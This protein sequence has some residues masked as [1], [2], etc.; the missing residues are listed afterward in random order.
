LR[1]S[2]GS[3]PAPGES[4][5]EMAIVEHEEGIEMAVVEKEG[6]IESG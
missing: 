4:V 2:S 3:P 5:V 6:G 1:A